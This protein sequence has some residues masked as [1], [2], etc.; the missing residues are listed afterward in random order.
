MYVIIT[1]TNNIKFQRCKNAI[2]NIL[3]NS[4]FIEWYLLNPSNLEKVGRRPD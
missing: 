2:L 3:S 1:R 4:H